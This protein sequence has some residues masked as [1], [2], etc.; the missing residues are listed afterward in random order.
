METGAGLSG[1][2]AAHST[3][4]ACTCHGGRLRARAGP[5]DLAGLP[6]VSLFSLIYGAMDCQSLTSAVIKPASS[7]C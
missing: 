5:S 7:L 2:H 6:G 3:A 1:A 4:L